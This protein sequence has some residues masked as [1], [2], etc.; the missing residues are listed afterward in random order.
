[1]TMQW[2]QLL[3]ADSKGKSGGTDADPKFI[4][5]DKPYKLADG[6]GL[7]LEV[8]PAGGKYWRLKYRFAGK[9]KRISLGVYPEVSL[10]GVACHRCYISSSSSSLPA[11]DGS[12]TSGRLRGSGLTVTDCS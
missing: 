1:M 6:A 9:E 3:S 10:A 11:A 5:T 8:D 2:E 12:A 4:A 7:Y